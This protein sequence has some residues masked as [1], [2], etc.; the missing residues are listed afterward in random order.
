VYRPRPT[1]NP[2]T[3]RAFGS[4]P[5]PTGTKGTEVPY[6]IDTARFRFRTAVH[7]WFVVRAVHSWFVV[8]TAVHSWFVVRGERR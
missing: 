4:E 7:S 6:S 1:R 5:V 2:E 8:H 3:E